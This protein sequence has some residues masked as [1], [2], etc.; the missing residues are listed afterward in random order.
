MIVRPLRSPIV[1]RARRSRFGPFRQCAA[2]LASLALGCGPRAPVPPPAAP[3]PVAAPA[4]EPFP[5]ADVW[6]RAPGVVLVR[7]SGSGVLPYASMRLQVLRADTADL[8]R[9]RCITCPV[10]MDGRVRR[11]DLVYRPADLATASADSLSAFILAFRE[12]VK[13]RDLAA[14]RAVMSPTFVHAADGPDGVLEAVSRWQEEAY[15]PLD[16]LP[17]LLDRGVAQVP[18]TDLWAAPPPFV[19]RS[20]YQQL[21]AGFRRVNGRWTWMFLVRGAAL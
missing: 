2:A 20:G 21:R 6:T 7:D 8:L 14:L 17:A 16:A 13:R 10:P 18:G 11:G 9:V 4:P 1:P 15:R 5:Y 19:T 3:A 12:A